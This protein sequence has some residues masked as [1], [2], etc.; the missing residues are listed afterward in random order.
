MT[1]Y[2][3]PLV[4]TGPAMPPGAAP[5]AGGWGW[6]TTLEVLERGGAPRFIDAS[7]LPTDVADR[8]CTPRPAI[9]GLDLAEPRVM[10]ILNA[11]P[12]SF[13]DGGR[14]E[15][16]GDAVKGGLAMIAQGVDLLDVGG[17]STRPGSAAV[18]V[19]EEIARVVPVIA[20]LRA[21]GAE[22]VISIDTRKMA[23]ARVAAQA[24]ADL[25]NDVAGFAFDPAL[26][27]FCAEAG[28]P[29]CVMHAQGEPETMQR[30]PR[31]DDV[32][33]DV[34]DHLAERIAALEAAGI[35]RARIIA[36]PGI[37]FG[38]TQA[39][40]LALLGRLGLFHG[41]GVP[42]LLG[43]SR[44]R[45]IGT[46]GG[47]PEARDRGPGSIGVAL[48]GLAQGVQF[49]RVHD[50]GETIQAIKLWRAAMAGSI[51]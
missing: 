13:S 42:L 25:V 18:P 44:K 31:Y 30:D 11:T 1:L 17:E 51:S 40:N 16:A 19:E 26:A 34:Y 43:A 22:C 3:R 49:L 45:F 27:P 21:A 7:D 47:A 29:V 14:H 50:V 2:Y 28:L 10:G 35:D 32:V 23:V 41:L 15:R 24:G 39:H 6:F 38:K 5:L 8:L 20:G 48:A 37:G 46:I 33:L 36:D 12:D 9:A 4:Q